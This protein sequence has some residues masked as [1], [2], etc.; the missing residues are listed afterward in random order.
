VTVDIPVS[1][2]GY[3]T[4]IALLALIFCVVTAAG[5]YGLGH[6]ARAVRHADDDPE[7]RATL[8]ILGCMM[9]FVGLLPTACVLGWLGWIRVV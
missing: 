9:V 5:W 4:G 3:V 1:W 2:V 6:I 7:G 8:V